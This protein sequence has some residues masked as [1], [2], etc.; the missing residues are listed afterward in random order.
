VVFDL[1]PDIEPATNSPGTTEEV[2]V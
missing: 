2:V 1:Q